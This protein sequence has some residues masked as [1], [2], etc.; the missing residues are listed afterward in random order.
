MK[1]LHIDTSILGGGSVSREVSALIVRKLVGEGGPTDI[2][3]R[4]LVK[5]NPPHLTLAALPGD[6]PLSALAGPLDAAAQAVRDTSQEMLDEFVSADTVV[7]GLP[8]YNFTVPSQFKAWIDRIVV[9]GKT[10]QYGASG[11]EGLA[12]NKRVIIAMARG[13]FYG[14]ETGGVSAEHAESYIR[15]VLTF[16]GIINPE[17]VI[18]DG[19]AAGDESKARAITAARDAIH[20]L[21]A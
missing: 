6:H 8:M 17:F 7:I 15:T 18:A 13:G 14:P 10:F 21:A 1:L 4:D 2:T 3:Y 12:G 20:R 11:V 5:E 9:P 16:I 19:V